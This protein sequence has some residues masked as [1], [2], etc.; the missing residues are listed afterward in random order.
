M[1]WSA[2]HFMGLEEKYDIKDGVYLSEKNFYEYEASVHLIHELIH[3]VVLNNTKE[4]GQTDSRGFEEG[5]C[6]V[7]GVLYFGSKILGKDLAKNLL[8]YSKFNYNKKPKL[9][10]QYRE[11]IRTALVF[12]K[13][14]G[15][16]GL[17][18]LVRK[19]R[20]EIKKAEELMLANRLDKI[21]LSKCEWTKDMND[22]SDELLM[23]QRYLVVSPLA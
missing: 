3:I 9:A 1:N 2:A 21:K 20:T 10:D 7:L 15:I 4:D 6:D 5:V 13:H 22:L 23:K 8:L 19:G 16:N 17:K 12:Y 11:N 14:F 18:E